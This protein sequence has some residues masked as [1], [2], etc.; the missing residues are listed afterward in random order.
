[1]PRNRFSR[2]LGRTQEGGK[3]GR[4]EEEG[5]KKGRRKGG[6]EIGKDAGRKDGGNFL[7]DFSPFIIIF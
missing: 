2:I 3:E 7:K 5:K 6:K 1:M 4:V